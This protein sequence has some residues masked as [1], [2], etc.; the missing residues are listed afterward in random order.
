MTG[1]DSGSEFLDGLCARTY[2]GDQ[3]FRLDDENVAVF[4]PLLAREANALNWPND[5]IPDIW[6]RQLLRRPGPR[7]FWKQVRSAWSGPLRGMCGAEPV[8]GL[9]GRMA[10]VLDERA[11]TDVNLVWLT[12][13]VCVRSLLP[14]VVT[15]LG[16]RDTAVITADLILKLRRLRVS[17]DE[18]WPVRLAA[19]LL[20]TQL[21]A[22]AVVRRELRGRAGGHRP[23]QPDLLD[24]IARDLLP[25]LGVGR[26]VDSVTGVLIAI[27]GPPGA[28]ASCLLY[29]LIRNPGWADRLAEELSDLAP[30]DLH[31]APITAAPVTHRFVKEVLRMWSAPVTLTRTANHRFEL[32]GVTLEAGHHYMLSPFVI[33]HNPALWPDPDTFDPDRWLPGSPRGATS[34]AHYVP[35][36]WPPTACIGAGLGTIQL[37]LLCHLL[38]T[39]Y[40][41]RPATP[42]AIGMRLAVVPMPSGMRGTVELRT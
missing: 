33:H 39:R 29:E 6:W 25:V 32:S 35:F 15:G 13:E 42:S 23:T 28:A 18:R 2:R 31:A 1:P 41:L 9:A 3:V 11:G 40:R 5:L 19:R 24:P 20:L 14:T 16:R 7:V 22:G 27:V 17:G 12:Q 37:I 30:A 36:G 10:G 4:D 38:N 26:A 8:A 34:G 21:R